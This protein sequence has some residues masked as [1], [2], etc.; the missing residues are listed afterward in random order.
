MMPEDGSELSEDCD[1]QAKPTVGGSPDQE[2]GVDYPQETNSASLVLL[3]DIEELEDRLLSASLQSK[4]L[5]QL[6]SRCVSKYVV[7][8]G[9]TL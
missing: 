8:I 3:N 6:C 9:V 4:V 7:G 1:S 2:D 5:F